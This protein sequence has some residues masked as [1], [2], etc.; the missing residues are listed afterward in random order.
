MTATPTRTVRLDKCAG[1]R[2][3]QTYCTEEGH[4]NCLLLPRGV[5]ELPDTKVAEFAI[6]QNNLIITFDRL[7]C[8]ESARVYSGKCPGLLLIRSD[9]NSNQQVN[10]KTVRA[11]L[12]K[13]KREFPDWHT[14]PWMN[15][16]VELTPTLI[17]VY[18]TWNSDPFHLTDIDRRPGG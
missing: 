5:R 4:V 6:A 9:E 15:S 18:H 16:F 10:T 7:F 12:E 13:F 8:A 2:K 17:V 11:I 14:V 3:L 1:S